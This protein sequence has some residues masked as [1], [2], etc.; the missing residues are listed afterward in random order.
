MANSFYA[1]GAEKVLAA[2]I[3]FTNDTIKAS[4]VKNTYV[5]NLATDEFYSAISTHVLGTNQ[6]LTG[7]TVAGGVFDAN[8]PTWS[9]V[10][11]GDTSEA[12]VIWKDT[13]NPATSPLLLYIDTI[14]GWPLATNGGDITA[15][16][17]DG[18]YK[19][20]ALYG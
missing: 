12:I 6:T 17:D 10:A 20:V 16:F 1:K 5:Q 15:K 14:T 9:T 11:A 19:I 13:G 8:D 3:S 4:L 7:K 18:G 2:G